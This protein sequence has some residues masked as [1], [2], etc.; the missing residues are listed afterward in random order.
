[1]SQCRFSIF[2]YTIHRCRCKITFLH[3]YPQLVNYYKNDEINKFN[4][5]MPLTCRQVII[6]IINF[7][8]YVTEI[9]YI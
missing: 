7:I 8:L 9:Q 1:M 5:V 6:I 4:T 3:Y 2:Y